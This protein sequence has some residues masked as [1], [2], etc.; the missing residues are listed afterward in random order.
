[1]ATKA[2]I[3]AEQYL[4]LS[5][6]HDYIHG[7]TAFLLAQAL[8]PAARSHALYPCF[9]VQMQVAPD[10]YRTPD[11]SVFAREEPRQSVPSEPP[12]LVI[13]IISTGDRH[14]ELM[15]ELEDYRAWGVSNVW[16]VNPL[17]KRFVVYAEWG[18]RNV[19]SLALAE[20]PFELTPETLFSDL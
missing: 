12:L 17:A 15:D 9:G 3:T 7:R 11:V 2:Q 14:R 19:A 18:L 8:V 13:E 5:F 4:N 20:Y 10:I 6:G 1:M 16:I